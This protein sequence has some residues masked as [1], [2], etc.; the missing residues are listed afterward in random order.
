MGQRVG[1]PRPYSGQMHKRVYSRSVGDLT[2]NPPFT[3]SH[4]RLNSEFCM[5]LYKRYPRIFQ[6]QLARSVGRKVFNPSTRATFKEEEGFDD[7]QSISSARSGK[8]EQPLTNWDCEVGEYFRHKLA[9]HESLTS[10]ALSEYSQTSG[11]SIKHRL[12][13]NS[14][15]LRQLLNERPLLPREK[16]LSDLGLQK[17]EHNDSHN[18]HLSSLKDEKSRSCSNDRRIRQKRYQP[19]QKDFDNLRTN[20][21]ITALKNNLKTSNWLPNQSSNQHSELYSYHDVEDSQMSDTDFEAGMQRENLRMLLVNPDSPPDS[22]ID[23]DTPSVRSLVSTDRTYSNSAL[24]GEQESSVFQVYCDI[25]KHLYENIEDMCK[26]ENGNHSDSSYTYT[27][28]EQNGDQNLERLGEY[29]VT[30]NQEKTEEERL[31]NVSEYNSI[32]LIVPEKDDTGASHIVHLGSSPDFSYEMQ[33]L[34]SDFEKSFNHLNILSPVIETESLDYETNVPVVVELDRLEN[35]SADQDSLTG[36]ESLTDQENFAGQDTNNES[37]AVIDSDKSNSTHSSSDSTLILVESDSDIYD[38]VAV[39]RNPNTTNEKAKLDSKA[40][41]TEAQNIGTMPGFDPEE[42]ANDLQI[43]PDVNSKLEMVAETQFEVYENLQNTRYEDDSILDEVNMLQFSQ[44]L[45]ADVLTKG[46]HSRTRIHFE[47]DT[48]DTNPELGIP[49][50]LADEKEIAERYRRRRSPSPYCICNRH[51]TARLCPQTT[52]LLSTRGFD[53]EG[54]DDSIS[55]NCVSLPNSTG[56]KEDK[57]SAHETLKKSLQKAVDQSHGRDFKTDVTGNIDV[58]PDL[59]SLIKIKQKL[60]RS[61]SDDSTFFQRD[62]PD[63]QRQMTLSTLSGSLFS[64]SSFSTIELSKEKERMENSNVKYME[65]ESRHLKADKGSE[66]SKSIHETDKATDEGFDKK[67]QTEISWHTKTDSYSETEG[68]GYSKPPLDH[69]VVPNIKGKK[70][71]YIPA[72]TSPRHAKNKIKFK[73]LFKSKKGSY[74][75]SW[76]INSCNSDEG[77]ETVTSNDTQNS[78]EGFDCS[79]TSQSMKLTRSLAG[80]Q[81]TESLDAVDPTYEMITSDHSKMEKTVTAS[82]STVNHNSQIYKTPEQSITSLP[83][84]VTPNES[85]KIVQME[86]TSDEVWTENFNPYEAI[87]NAEKLTDGAESSSFSAKLDMVDKKRKTTALRPIVDEVND[88]ELNIEQIPVDV[89][90]HTRLPSQQEEE[91]EEDF[92]KYFPDFIM[93]EDASKTNGSAI[94]A[95]IDHQNKTRTTS[96]SDDVSPPTSSRGIDRRGGNSNNINTDEFGPP[97]PD[98]NYYTSNL[99]KSQELSGSKLSLK[100]K[101]SGL[102]NAAKI[103]LLSLR[104]SAS[105]DKGIDAAGTE[106]SPGAHKLPPKSPPSST[107]K[108]PSSKT[109]KSIFGSKKKKADDSSDGEHKEVERHASVPVENPLPLQKRQQWSSCQ[110]L[111]SIQSSSEFQSLGKLLQ[112]NPDGSQLIQLIRPSNEQLGFFIAKG[113]AKFNNGNYVRGNKFNN[114]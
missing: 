24:D 73:N 19:N 33:K 100:K 59:I 7:K 109:F 57:S 77:F 40:T 54:G 37:N 98:R 32:P 50:V 20:L 13:Q 3:E 25:P 113:N 89:K 43:S 74:N 10:P 71:R 12:Q 102:K 21:E 41:A 93:D 62:S 78:T 64:E 91:E 82:S 1:T 94:Y 105:M 66:V 38:D 6:K 103:K 36:Q 110:D 17:G 97:L 108:T 69:S 30:D 60:S 46:G 107:K 81:S 44:E 5:N 42:F 76:M 104:K 15:K 84:E 16:A 99:E 53:I 29:H 112:L 56:K 9:S 88:Q 47:D 2:A 67:L 39:I 79:E 90:V 23:V 85:K 45:S 48:D 31:L 83:K 26:V 55:F 87:E 49:E 28:C 68:H 51:N 8:S 14:E 106:K 70:G 80:A 35:Q 111:D 114:N 95:Q 86:V 18:R 101:I 27:D 96:K 63:S 34:V 65:N 52:S 92:N 58:H 22:A 4:T 72:I 75:P 11:L 61:Y